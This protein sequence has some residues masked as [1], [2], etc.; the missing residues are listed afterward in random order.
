[1]ETIVFGL[2][3]SGISGIHCW[4]IV[5][6]VPPPLPPILVICRGQALGLKGT[7]YYTSSFF[8]LLH[9]TDQSNRRLEPL[10]D[11][12][13]LSSS[14]HKHRPNPTTPNQTMPNQTMPNRTIPYRTKTSQT[15]PNLTKPNHT[16]PNPTGSADEGTTVLLVKYRYHL[17]WMFSFD[18]S[19]LSFLS[20]FDCTA[21]SLASPFSSI[22]DCI[23]NSL[24]SYKYL[25]APRTT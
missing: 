18:L 9:N 17:N 15:I 22:F 7:I 19:S 14:L 24:A 6:L 23:A 1:M 10:L 20:I 5:L 4:K 21:S 12:C 16:K 11:G 3:G 2:N 8:L 13:L 25:I